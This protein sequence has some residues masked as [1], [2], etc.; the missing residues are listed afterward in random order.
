MSDS[1]NLLPF[2]NDKRRPILGGGGL[3]DPLVGGGLIACSL[4]LAS[5]AA[6]ERLAAH[7]EFAC[8]RSLLFASH[9]ETNWVKY[10][11]KIAD[12]SV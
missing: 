5:Q 6:V 3:L 1:Y 7:A 2:Q 8:E 11:W 4:S 10:P 9:D 12:R